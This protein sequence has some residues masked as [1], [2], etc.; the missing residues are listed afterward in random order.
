[1]NDEIETAEGDRPS[2]ATTPAPSGERRSVDASVEIRASPEAVWRA[3]TEA[4]EIERW[5]ALEARVEPGEGG[6]IFLSWKNEYQGDSR[7]LVWDPPFL[8]RVEWVEGSEVT[9]YRIED[10]GERTLLRVVSSFPLDAAWDD[11][12]EGTRRG[13]RFMLASLRQYVEHHAGEDRQL[14]YLRRR[15][16]LSAEEI[17]GRL[18][19]S[20]GVDRRLMRGE[21]LD[22]DPPGHVVVMTADPPGTLLQIS[23][24]PNMEAEGVVD[25]AV[26]HQ[27]WGV[28]AETVDRLRAA[29]QGELER[30]LPEGANV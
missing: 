23:T 5:F 1:M 7:I 15:A 22:D 8:L 19:G 11:W 29:W 28:P 18:M 9:E 26:W 16:T 14:V 24:Q 25:A 20:G 12:V 4:R 30:L 17:W 10:A 2:D 21:V 27:G 13:W 6:N 3:L